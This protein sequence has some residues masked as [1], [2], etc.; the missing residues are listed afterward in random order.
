MVVAEVQR[1]GKDKLQPMLS[2]VQFVPEAAFGKWREYDTGSSKR[3]PRSEDGWH[4]LVLDV[5]P[6]AIRMT[7]DDAEIAVLT[8]EKRAIARE[9]LLRGYPEIRDAARPTFW[10]GGGVGLR[11]GHGSAS[12]RRVV[13]TPQ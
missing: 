6:E 1:A 3:V 4:H 9:K 10:P 13:L 8:Q 12:F 5:S 7:A 2:P 11:I